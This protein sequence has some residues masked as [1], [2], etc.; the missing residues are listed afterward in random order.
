MMYVPVVTRWN[1]WVEFVLD[2]GSKNVGDGVGAGV[3][4]NTSPLKHS[5]TKFQI[6]NS[7]SI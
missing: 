7:F 2:L 6:F 1:C 5:I 4:A 3:E